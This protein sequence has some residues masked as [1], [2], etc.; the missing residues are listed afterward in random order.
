M[1]DRYATD[2][3]ERRG[4]EANGDWLGR[5]HLGSGPNFVKIS[6]PVIAGR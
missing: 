1:V 6:A 5:F 2:M 3:Q 4:F